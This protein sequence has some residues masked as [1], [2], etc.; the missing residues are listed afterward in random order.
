[1][2]MGNNFKSNTKKYK[3]EGESNKMHWDLIQFNG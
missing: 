2:S 3:N 1:M